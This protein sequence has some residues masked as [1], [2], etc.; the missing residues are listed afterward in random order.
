MN[1]IHFYNRL[2]VNILK[3]KEQFFDVLRYKLLV[4]C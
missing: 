3:V 1:L 2:S 4:V